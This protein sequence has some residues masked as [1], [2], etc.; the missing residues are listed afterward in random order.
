MHTRLV[1][2]WGWR[3]DSESW[4]FGIYF[5]KGDILIVFGRWVFARYTVEPQEEGG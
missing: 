4:G 1:S 2:R 5:W 3:S